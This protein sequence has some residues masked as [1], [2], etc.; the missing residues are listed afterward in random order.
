MFPWGGGFGGG[1]G[2]GWWMQHWLKPQ[3]TF[4]LATSKIEIKST[5]SW[6]SL[7]QIVAPH[8]EFTKALS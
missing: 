7:E 1:G 2:G 5:T 8:P 6:F 3:L 4:R